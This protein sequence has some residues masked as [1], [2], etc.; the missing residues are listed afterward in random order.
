MVLEFCHGV[1]GERA[2]VP[3]TDRAVVPPGSYE[4]FA[5]VPVDHVHVRGVGYG[6]DQ[7]WFRG[8]AR[9]PDLDATEGERHDTLEGNVA[10]FGG[11]DLS[12]FA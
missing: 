10:K 3:N 2:K 12:K 1:I 4:W 11:G 9:V 7:H 8:G 6:V 5:G